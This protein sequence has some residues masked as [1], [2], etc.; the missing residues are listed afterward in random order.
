MRPE[1][2]ARKSGKIF[3]STN[4]LKLALAFFLVKCPPS[5]DTALSCLAIKL[6]FSNSK[7]T[8]KRRSSRMQSCP[9]LRWKG[10]RR[11]LLQPFHTSSLLPHLPAQSYHNC[12]RLT[13][14]I[15]SPSLLSNPFDLGS[16]TTDQIMQFP[17]RGGLTATQI[18]LFLLSQP[19]K[20]VNFHMILESKG[21]T[22][23]MYS[24]SI[25]HDDKM[26]RF[27]DHKNMSH[28]I[29]V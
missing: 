20:E 19:I 29:V 4:Q 18:L 13:I 27:Q 7:G 12:S 1:N 26:I 25:L 8:E 15:A 21:K 9:L 22:L 14:A 28:L 2:S 23:N 17:K 5:L 6:G 16:Q 11:R 24:F 3:L 10:I